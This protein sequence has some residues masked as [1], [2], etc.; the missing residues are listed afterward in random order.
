MLEYR[1]FYVGERLDLEQVLDHLMRF[2][3]QR[4]PQVAGSS[5]RT[6]AP[7]HG[8]KPAL[9]AMPHWPPAQ[10]ALRI[11][12]EQHCGDRCAERLPLSVRTQSTM[13]TRRKPRC[14]GTHWW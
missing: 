14:I 11:Q 13:E 1:R 2:G 3:Y 8:W 5:S 7:L 10:V 4:V 12:N 6:Q 9:H